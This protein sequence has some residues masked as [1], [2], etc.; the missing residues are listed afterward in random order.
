MQNHTNVC[1]HWVPIENLTKWYLKDR[2]KLDLGGCSNS[3][4][5]EDLNPNLFF[6]LRFKKPLIRKTENQYLSK[7]DILEGLKNPWS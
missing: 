1:Y 6:S 3:K 5:G 4:Y 7:H 2:L